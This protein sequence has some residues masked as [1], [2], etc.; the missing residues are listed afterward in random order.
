MNQHKVIDTEM[1]RPIH[2]ERY[3]AL[4]HSQLNSFCSHTL[5]LYFDEASTVQLVM[6]PV[7][8]TLR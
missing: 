1:Q 7:I 4:Y 3:T 5:E 6:A 2:I 8:S